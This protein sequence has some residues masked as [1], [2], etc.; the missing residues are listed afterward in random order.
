MY[1]RSIELINWRSYR[2]ARFEFPI[3]DGCR[4]VILITAPNEYGKTSFFEALTLGLFGRLGLSLVPRAHTVDGKY[5]ERLTQNYSQFLNK[6]LH[7]RATESGPA[8]CSVIIEV[9][10]DDEEPIELSRTWHFNKIGQ[11]KPGDDDLSIFYGHAREP[12]NPPSAIE[13]DDQWYQE[14]IAH[15]F[16]HHNLAKFFFFDG[17][18]VQRYAS[19]EMG[20][21][22]RQGIEGLLGLPILRDLK[23]SLEKYSHSQR[24]LVM[25]PS[26]NRIKK[27]ET[28][29]ANISE[30]IEKDKKLF[31]EATEALPKIEARINDLT[32]S[33]GGQ[34]EITTAMVKQSAKDEQS[35][36][37]EAKRA[38]EALIELIQG[39]VALAVA[40]SNL[41]KRTSE[42]LE[43]EAKRERWEI[44]RDEGSQNLERFSKDLERRVLLLAPPLDKNHIKAVVEASKD[45]WDA[46]W[47]PAPK[48]C[49]EEYRHSSLKSTVR[50]RTIE[51]LQSLDN[52]NKGEVVGRVERFNIAVERAESKKR[53]WQ[54][55]ESIAPLAEEL[56]KEYKEQSEKSGHYK[57]QKDKA[58]RAIQANEA[59]L[60]HKR[61]EFGRYISSKTT[62]APALSR[63]KIAGR[64]AD[65]IQELLEE[66]LPIEVAEI[67][68][69]MTRAWKSMAHLSDRLDRFEITPDCRVKML[70]GEG[71]DIHLIDKSAG[72]SQV[73]TQALITAITRVSKRTFPFVV[74]TPLARLSHE[75]RIGVLKTFTDRDGQVILL[76]TD[77]EVVGDKLESI[78]ERLLATFELRIRNDRGIVETSVHKTDLKDT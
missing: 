21:Q 41:R 15:R 67:A 29:I 65:L 54:E 39:D 69:E 16:L 32:Q 34:G 72:A 73:F 33:L 26:D 55:L 75:Q 46:L 18:Q 6:V 59:E 11:H 78:R 76:S 77:E 30:L 48:D 27:V 22:V 40:G 51:I 56:L 63:A 44:G 10:D 14:W 43:A 52:H 4:N 71:E 36:R 23:E 42:R 17:E 2:H 19:R 12:V 60:K 24:K 62:G 74:D 35:Y 9:V 64:Y 1:L 68:Q 61:K 50:A 49:P 70:N 13:N 38:I 45:A 5:D 57:S 28:D 37:D 58:E 25:A 8:R 66:A 47:N 20:E 7:H 3:P 53:E 31:L